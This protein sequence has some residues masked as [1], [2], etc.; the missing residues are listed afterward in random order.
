MGSFL[1][2]FRDHLKRRLLIGLVIFA[3]FGLTIYVLVKLV[4]FGKD[5]LTQPMSDLLQW[6]S[7]NYFHES[8]EQFRTPDGELLWWI[9][10]PL[11]FLSIAMVILILYFIC[12]L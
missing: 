2:K 1:K 12:L 4:T 9:D 5:R 8:M 7:A 10:Y 6:L 11:L 3:P